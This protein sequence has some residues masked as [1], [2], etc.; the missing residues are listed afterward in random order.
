MQKHELLVLG[1]GPA[2]ISAA[3]YAK[4]RGIDVAIIEKNKI[5][6]LIATASKVSHYTGLIEN[7]S[8]DSFSQRLANQLKEA[9]IKVIKAEIS[10]VDLT[11]SPKTITLKDNANI[12]AADA[13]IIALGSTPKQPNYDVIEDV[14]HIPNEVDINSVQNKTVI[15]LGG[16]DAAAKEAIALAKTAK[17]VVMVQDQSEL[18][19]IAEFKNKLDDLANFTAITTATLKSI[20]YQRATNK[21]KEITIKTDTGEKHFTGDLA[22]FA[23]IGQTPN[24]ELLRSQITLANGFVQSEDT[25]TG[26]AG[27]FVAGDLRTKQVRQVATAVADGAIAAISCA[28]YL[29]NLK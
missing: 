14:Y 25:Q 26:I 13:V 28:K 12:L 7:E 10:A 8:G 21:I 29:A 17:Q 20:H 27:V 16:S 11:A 18:Q 23:F 2:G 1:A 22:I 24:S 15:V 9:E 3:L 19:M 4:S 6:G 5:G